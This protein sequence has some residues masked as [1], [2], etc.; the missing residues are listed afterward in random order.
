MAIRQ[1][2]LHLCSVEYFMMNKPVLRPKGRG[3]GSDAKV[4]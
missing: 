2:L 1:C 4:R 3:A